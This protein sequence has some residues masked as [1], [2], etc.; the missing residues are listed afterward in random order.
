MKGILKMG[1]R[2]RIVQTSSVADLVEAEKEIE[3]LNHH[4]SMFIKNLKVICD[5][6]LLYREVLMFLKVMWTAFRKESQHTSHDVTYLEVKFPL[7]AFAL[8]KD[9][10]IAAKL[11]TDILMYINGYNTFRREMVGTS[12]GYKADLE[13][14]IKKFEEQAVVE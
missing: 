10:T 13:Q 1:I 11:C 2:S 9:K 6:E 4:G 5:R 7:M 8:L 3:N 12:I 14:M